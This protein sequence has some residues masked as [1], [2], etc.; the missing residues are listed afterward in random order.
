MS[1]AEE[2]E[3]LRVE[4]GARLAELRARIEAAANGVGRAP[5]SITCVA[6]S[7]LQSPAKI[8]AAHALGLREFG[9]NY[10][11]ELEQK[12][13]TLKLPG[14]RWNFIGHLQSNKAKRL[15]LREVVV[16]S[17]DRES[18]AQVLAKQ[19]EALGRKL[20]VFVQ[21]NLAAEAQKSGCS[22][23]ELPTLLEAITRLPALQL[24]GLMTV[25]PASEDAEDARPYFARLRLLAERFGLAE[26]SMGMSHDYEVAIAEGATRVRIGSAL[27]G[28]RP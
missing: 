27:F 5:S 13:E 17:L 9:E 12:A 14:L 21:V 11:Q 20:E 19:A 7:K 8:E 25:P 26:L 10:V 1:K 4:L 28:A 6:V 18:L 16:E 3:A 22:E 24:R 2:V 15:L 23:A